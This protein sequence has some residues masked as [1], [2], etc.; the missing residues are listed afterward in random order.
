ME[1]G[2]NGIKTGGAVPRGLRRAAGKLAWF[3][4]L[5]VIGLLAVPVGLLVLMISGIWGLT[6]RAAAWGSEAGFAS[7]QCKAAEK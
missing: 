5:G 6:S 3:A 7:K 1:G 4:G 2:R